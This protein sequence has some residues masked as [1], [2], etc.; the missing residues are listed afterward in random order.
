MFVKKTG[1]KIFGANLT[2]AERTAMQMEIQRELAEF[3]RKHMLEIDAIVLWGLHAQLGFG[4]ERLKK[5]YDHFAE[6]MDDL[7]NRY[8]MEQ[9]DKVWLCTHKLKELGIDIEK[10]DR[11]RKDT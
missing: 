10:W 7:V 5:F 9:G 6:S 8:E 1:G 3:D 2:A 4:V 11:E